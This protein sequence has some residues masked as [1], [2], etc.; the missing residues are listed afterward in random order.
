MLMIARKLPN[1]FMN[2]VDISL[3][4]DPVGYGRR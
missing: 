4:K 1:A 3:E 2:S